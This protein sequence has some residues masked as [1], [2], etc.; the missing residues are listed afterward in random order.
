MKLRFKKVTLENF[1]SFE[2]AE[3]N[4]TSHGY[5]L[6]QGKNN[7]VTDC[8]YSNGSGKSTI[9]ESIIWCLCGET[10]RGSKDTCNKLTS[11]GAKV[12]LLFD[13]DSNEYQVIRY[14]EYKPVGTNLKIFINGEDKSGKGIRDTEKLLAEYLPDL[15]A[16]LI[17]SVIIL[18]QGLPMR[19]SNNTPSG[20]K[21]V[22]EKLSKSDFMLQDLKD[23]VS[24]RKDFLSKKIR[25]IEDTILSLST[26]ESILVENINS[27]TEEKNKLE[28]D[29]SDV[30]DLSN[31]ILF[32]ERHLE[33]LK[34]SKQEADVLLLDTENALDSHTKE[35]EEAKQSFLSL[36]TASL[37]QF[38][39][40]ISF[41][42]DICSTISAKIGLIR[43][44]IRSIQSIKDI[45]PTCG[46]K[47]PG[48]IKPSTTSQEE[49]L[50]KLL[51]EFEKHKLAKASLLTKKEARKMELEDSFLSRKEYYEE[52]ISYYK[53]QLNSIRASINQ[54]SKQITDTSVELTSLRY[55]KNT[56]QEHLA[57]CKEAIK[58]KELELEQ[59]QSDLL[60]NN[61]EKEIWQLHLDYINKMNTALSREFR[62]YLLTSV[63]EF[64]NNK[65]KE[66]CM[67]VFDTDKI[68]FCLDGNNILISYDGKDYSNLSGGERQKVDLIVQFAIR[69]MLCKYLN[70]SSNIL[71][72]DELFDNLDSIGCERALNLVSKLTD[73]ESIFVVTHHSDIPIPSDSI[74]LVEKGEDGIRRISNA[75]Y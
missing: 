51:D 40:E 59:L 5:T 33:S 15:T 45:C 10:I 13:V 43:E 32:L 25:G 61:N 20:R 3:I 29:S 1:L 16:S 23:R 11:N 22:L 50:Q 53:N 72:I 30:D 63:I 4:F 71:A 68:D 37:K 73:V 69:D 58:A 38:E 18:G 41:E 21:D 47:M 14:K 60:Y 36:Q 62:G 42:K 39:D 8:A 64:I 70:F 44:E 65:S 75:I 56:L 55:Q 6:V 48:V 27:L 67:A 2:K 34:T 54:L 52:K 7:C 35:Y 57:S 9:F 66:Y 49:S 26:K 19:F 24:K 28:S 74:L 31:K 46:Q 17:G 12:D